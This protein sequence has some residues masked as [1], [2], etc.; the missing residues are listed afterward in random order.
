MNRN[1]SLLLALAKWF[2]FLLVFVPFIVDKHVFF[3]YIESKVVLMRGAAALSLLFLALFLI[4]AKRPQKERFFGSKIRLL[5]SPT[6]ILVGLFLVSMAISVVFAKDSYRAFFGNVE[7][8]E[9]LVG[10]LFFGAIFLLALLLFEH[11]EWRIFF[12]ATVAGGI[13]LVGHQLVQI[14]QTQG[15]SRPF[16]TLGNPS[17]LAGYLLFVIFSALALAGD[18]LSKPL[19]KDKALNWAVFLLLGAAAVLAA[20][21]IVLSETRGAFLGFLAGTAVAFL[22][23]GYYFISSRFSLNRRKIFLAGTALFILLAGFAVGGLFLAR[24]NFSPSE[25]GAESSFLVKAVQRLTSADAFQTRLIA[26]KVSLNS[27]SPKNEGVGKFLIGWGPEN[28]NIAYNT[29]FDPQYFKYEDVWFD[30]A[31]NKILDVLVMQGLLGLFVYLGLWGSVVGTVFRFRFNTQQSDVPGEVRLPKYPLVNAAILFFAVS[32]FIHLLFLFDTPAATVGLF[33]FFGFVAFNNQTQTRTQMHMDRNTDA[34]INPRL[35]VFTSV[36]ISVA[37]IAAIILFIWATW[38][39][40]MQMK[41]Y[42]QLKSRETTIKEF[43]AELDDVLASNTYAQDR[44]IIDLLKSLDQFPKGEGIADLVKKIGQAADKL[45]EREP[46]EPRYPM[47]V[48]QYIENL[49]LW[50]VAE[51]YHRKALVLAPKRPDLIYLLGQNL[52]VQGKYEEGKQVLDRILEVAPDVPL[53]RIL[54]SVAFGSVIDQYPDQ[55]LL[56]RSFEGMEEGLSNPNVPLQFEKIS[57]IRELYQLYIYDFY[58]LKDE[59]NFLKALTRAEEIEQKWE[60]MAQGMYLQGKLS[61]PVEGKSEEYAKAI[62]AFKEKGW[63]AIGIQAE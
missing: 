30:R 25:P 15:T 14:A 33:M 61:K 23:F 46:Y 22:Y 28:Y 38:L 7:R 31:H 62:E 45:I 26:A 41:D 27:I 2:L 4:F 59:E 18:F 43:T 48:A 36:C 6:A 16:A 5:K 32:Y 60:K 20:V 8:G 44:I 50:Q 49:G 17:F 9:G 3:P 42:I 12:A 39:P 11:K 13:I 19:L 63:D 51:P 56:M 47:N 57:V 24:Q 58:W 53:A 54:Y 55:D 35:L 34:Y 29:Y 37:A 40:Y 52:L 10:F 21:G 1:N